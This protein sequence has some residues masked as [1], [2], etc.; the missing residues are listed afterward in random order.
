MKKDVILSIKPKY[1]KEIIDGKK[2]FEFRKKSFDK[3]KI[4]RV[5]IYSSSPTQAIVGYFETDEILEDTPERIWEQTSQVAGINKQDFFE[6]FKDRVSAA[7]IKIE[8]FHL[9]SNPINPKEVF[10]KFCPPQS[11]MYA[12]TMSEKIM[13]SAISA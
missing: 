9:F 6:Y 3:D 4:N 13:E 11:Y 5:F 8:N 7:A 2:H 12:D 10:D 1:V